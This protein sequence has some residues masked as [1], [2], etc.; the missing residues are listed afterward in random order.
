MKKL[1]RNGI[2]GSVNSA[3]I[4]CSSWKSQQMRVEKK[5]RKKCKRSFSQIQTTPMCPFYG[6]CLSKACECEY[7][8]F[9]TTCL[10]EACFIKKIIPDSKSIIRK[11]FFSFFDRTRKSL[12]YVQTSY[13]FLFFCIWR[14]NKVHFLI[15]ITIIL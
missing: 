8:G 1:L 7:V 5:K 13:S 12:M 10:W 3:Q 11:S 2:C 4:H 6:A 15:L 9:T 14:P